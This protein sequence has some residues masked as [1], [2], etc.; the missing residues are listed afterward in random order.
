MRYRRLLLTA[1]DRERACLLA[2]QT[3]RIFMQRNQGG[4]WTPW[5]CKIPAFDDLQAWLYLLKW[6]S[7]VR[8]GRTL[9]WNIG[10]LTL[11]LKAVG[12]GHSQSQPLGVSGA[13]LTRY[14]PVRGQT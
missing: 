14:M 8:H 3:R 7:Q 6:R 5:L 1:A 11:F 9:A 10:A 12:G 13:Q 4:A 2:N